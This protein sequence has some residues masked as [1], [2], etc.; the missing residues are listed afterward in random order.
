VYLG[1]LIGYYQEK[2][3]EIR[4]TA[5]S[6][7]ALKS[8]I[9]AGIILTD[10][11]FKLKANSTPVLPSDAEETARIAETLIRQL[12]EALS[13]GEGEDSGLS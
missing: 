2:I 6:A 10:E 13:E 8:S 7:D 5:P 1:Q 12:S 4:R 3:E 9:L 11:L